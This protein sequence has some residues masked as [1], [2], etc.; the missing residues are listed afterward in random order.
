MKIIPDDRSMIP[1][2]LDNIPLR[3]RIIGSMHSAPKYRSFLIMP[4][5]IFIGCPAR[6]ISPKISVKSAMFP[7]NSVPSPMLGSPL[8]AEMMLMNPSG[9][10]E[11]NAIM[12]K[13]VV[14]SVSLK[15]LARCDT[16][17]TAYSALFTSTMQPIMKI[18][19]S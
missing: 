12:M 13:L 1:S 19:T 15:N 7:P 9:S 16:A 14:N 8:S 18:S 6:A 10:D 4:L 11:T 5:C 2:S 17:L 3:P